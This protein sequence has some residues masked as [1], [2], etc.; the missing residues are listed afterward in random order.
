MAGFFVKINKWTARLAI[1]GEDF[2]QIKRKVNKLQH[3]FSGKLLCK[4]LQ[5]KDLQIAGNGSRTRDI[6][7]GKVALYH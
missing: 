2:Y 5:D 4:P 3:P 6:D 7:L 1:L